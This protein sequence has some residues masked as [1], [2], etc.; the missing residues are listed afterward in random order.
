[1]TSPHVADLY[2]DLGLTREASRAEITRAYRDLL[3]RHHPDTRTYQHHPGPNLAPSHSA[4]TDSVASD[5]G[6]AASSDEALNRAVAAYAVLTDPDRRAS[7]DHQQRNHRVEAEQHTQAEA[8]GPTPR[9]KPAVG[10]FWPAG[11][12]LVGSSRQGRPPIQV[13]PVRWHR[14]SPATGRRP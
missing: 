1:M 11:V 2:A 5:S 9:T 14:V 4:P 8:A 10:P 12:T 7:Y 3:R 6:L 13:G